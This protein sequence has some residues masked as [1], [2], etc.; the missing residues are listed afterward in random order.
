MSE[1]KAI[2]NDVDRLANE[3]EKLQRRL[4]K[5]A[6]VLGINIGEEVYTNSPEALALIAQI[7]TRQGV[8]KCDLLRSTDI[9]EQL[10]K[11]GGETYSASRVGQLMGSSNRAVRRTTRKMIKGELVQSRVW[12]VRNFENYLEMT[13]TQ[14]HDEYMKQMERVESTVS[15]V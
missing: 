15:F 3:T 14:I 7:E 11:I 4:K 1:L 12:I 13:P 6:A 5:Y 9:V 2:L 8:F 10:Q